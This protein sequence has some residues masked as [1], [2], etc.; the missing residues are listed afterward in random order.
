MN[1]PSPMLASAALL[2][3]AASAA[4]ASAP[5][6]DAWVG[7]MPEP[8]VELSLSAGLVDDLLGVT[9]AAIAGVSAALHE[10]GSDQVEL[11]TQQVE[12]VQAVVALV[13]DSLQG[14]RLR[15]YE[16]LDEPTATRLLAGVVGSAEADGLETVLRVRDG[17]DRV[18]AS[19]KRQDGSIRA[20]S[21]V[22]CDGGGA[23]HV[24][25][26]CD[27]APERAREL[28]ETLT[29]LGLELGLGD[30]VES[31]LE[32]MQHELGRNAELRRAEA[33]AARE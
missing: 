6:G 3:M 31:G 28:A 26:D 10:H 23:V 21:L 11:T 5:A 24:T 30:A 13:K 16:S 2:L 15:V 14:V 17:A 7:D 4:A 32:Q 18:Q 29:R 9:D 25:A 27:L 19:L 8:K 33:A 22:A 1:V 12:A 20:L